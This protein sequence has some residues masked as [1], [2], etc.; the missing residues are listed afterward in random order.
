[1]KDMRHKQKLTL[2]NVK[3]TKLNNHDGQW[4]P[5]TH[6]LTEQNVQPMALLNLATYQSLKK[7]WAFTLKQLYFY[8]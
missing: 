7:T 5:S 2:N 1:M 6:D 3:Y 8:T 4:K